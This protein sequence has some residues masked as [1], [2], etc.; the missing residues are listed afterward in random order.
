MKTNEEVAEEAK[1]AARE[2][3]KIWRA[4][5]SPAVAATALSMSLYYLLV[6][7]APD[8]KYTPKE[9]LEGIAEVVRIFLDGDD[10]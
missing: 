6:E 5:S 8:P 7:A 9:Q 1:I 2:M 3:R 4:L 10:N